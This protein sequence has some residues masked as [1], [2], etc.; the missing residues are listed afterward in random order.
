MAVK[1]HDNYAKLKIINKTVSWL[2]YLQKKSTTTKQWNITV[3][4]VIDFYA[5]KIPLK[6]VSGSNYLCT[7][8]GMGSL[9]FS[10]WKPFF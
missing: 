9:T 3:I 8:L 6:F 2:A 1:N 7:N 4:A 5:D 10:K